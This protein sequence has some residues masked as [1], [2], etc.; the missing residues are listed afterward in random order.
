MEP[1]SSFFP[2]A[3][4]L[5]PNT[6]KVLSRVIVLPTGTAVTHDDIDVICALMRYIVSHGK[7]IR[8][9]LSDE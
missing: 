8:E 9:M 4:L 7:K 1:Y 2:H 5:L 3:G 6:D